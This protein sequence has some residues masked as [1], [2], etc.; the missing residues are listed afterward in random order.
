MSR[1]ISSNGQYGVKTAKQLKLEKPF[2]TL[3]TKKDA[4]HVPVNQRLTTLNS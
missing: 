3:R 2:D 1:S 4:Q